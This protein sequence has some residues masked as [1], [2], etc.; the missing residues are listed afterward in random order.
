MFRKLGFVLILMLCVSGLALAQ[1]ADP[2]KI[3]LLTDHS[4]PLAIYGTEL[5]N[6]F[7]LGL[8]YSVG[9]NPD[10]YETI[11]DAVAAVTI[12]GRPVELL[13][14]DTASDPDTGASQAREVLEQ[15]GAEILVGAPSSGVTVGLQQVAVDYDVVLFAAPGASPAITG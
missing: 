2:L 14:R 9:L 7:K 13:V 10:Y 5:D 3:G 8:V 11:D 1:D 15:D 4:G 6:G 12:A